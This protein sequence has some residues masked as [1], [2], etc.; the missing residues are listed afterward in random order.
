M[1]FQ[2]EL[3][4]RSKHRV[5]FQSADDSINM[6]F[7]FDDPRNGTAEINWIQLLGA[8][9]EHSVQQNDGLVFVEAELKTLSCYVELQ[10]KSE[11]NP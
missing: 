10:R 3:L 6:G 2:I 1:P 8:V 7:L 11:R 9:M 4:E 5:L